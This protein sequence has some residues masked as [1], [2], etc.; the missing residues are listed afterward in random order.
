MTSRASSALLR[1]VDGDYRDP[2]TFDALRQALGEAVHPTCYLA[3]PPSL[4][5]TVADGLARV[6]LAAGSRLIVEKP[7]GRDARR[8]GH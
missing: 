7:F 1:Y 2:G 3:V 5:G 6:G 8:R 4:F